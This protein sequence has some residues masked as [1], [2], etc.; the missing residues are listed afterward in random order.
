[1]IDN[2]LL[3]CLMKYL[4]FVLF[5]LFTQNVNANW[6]TFY[7][8]QIFDAKLL[9]NSVYQDEQKTQALIELNFKEKLFSDGVAS[10]VLFLEHICGGI[11]PSIIE[12]KFY[13]GAAN[14]SEELVM[15]DKPEKFEKYVI[16]TFPNLIK[17]ICI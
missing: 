11:R 17:Q 16:K 13:K 7:E 14:K 8:S 4:I 6:V 15:N 2:D 9:L 1:M 5:F 10:H 12:E 3:G